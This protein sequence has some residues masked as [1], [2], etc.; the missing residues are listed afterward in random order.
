MFGKDAEKKQ[1]STGKTC[2]LN[3]VSSRKSIDCFVGPT[4]CLDDLDKPFLRNISGV[5]S[6]YSSECSAEYSSWHKGDTLSLAAKCFYLKHDKEPFKEVSRET[7]FL[8]MEN[9]FFPVVQD[10]HFDKKSCELE[11]SLLEDVLLG[12]TG[13]VD[14]VVHDS[15]K[16]F[17]GFAVN[18]Q[19]T[20][21]PETSS[22]LED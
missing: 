18:D 8:S 2:L 17:P 13:T 10:S 15:S 21:I 12:S 3:P 9:S 7:D 4:L 20:T 5:Y 16:D 19:D 14:S 1:Q 22:V 6:P 11:K